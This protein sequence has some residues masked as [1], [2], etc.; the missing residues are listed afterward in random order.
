M[1]HFIMQNTFQVTHVVPTGISTEGCESVRV[2]KY[3]SKGQN[4]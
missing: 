3:Y 2:R 4:E 1:N